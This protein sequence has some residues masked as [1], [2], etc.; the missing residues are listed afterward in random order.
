M[1]PFVSF[2]LINLMPMAHSTS[3][4]ASPREERLNFLRAFARL[5]SPVTDN[6]AEARQLARTAARTAQLPS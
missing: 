4:N 6:V 5:Y 2:T 1:R 3:A